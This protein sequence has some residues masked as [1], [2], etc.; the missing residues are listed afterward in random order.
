MGQPTP[1]IGVVS[2]VFVRQMEFAKAGDVEAGHKHAYDHMTLLAK[3]AIRIRIGDDVSEFK[4]PM[5]ILIRADQEHELTA[6]EDE[7]VAYCVHGLRGPA[8]RQFLQQVVAKG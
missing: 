5:L 2:N 3:G 7:T 1:R 6:L 4:A 8:L